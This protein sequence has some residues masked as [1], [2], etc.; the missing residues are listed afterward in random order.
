M[1]IVQFLI[2]LGLSINVSALIKVGFEFT[3]HG[4][5]LFNPTRTHM[6]VK[7]DKGIDTTDLH[8]HIVYPDSNG[9]FNIPT[10]FITANSTLKLT[11]ESLD[12]TFP[13]P[14]FKLS[15][16]SNNTYE[17]T[18]IQE[19][20]M[21]LTLSNPSTTNVTSP[22][23]YLILQ[24]SQY[25]F[26]P[27]RFIPADSLKPSPMQMMQSIPFLA[28][29]VSSKWTIGI[30]ILLVSLAAIP[31]VINFFDPGFA[32]RM[33][34]AQLEQQRAEQHNKEQQQKKDN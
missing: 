5:A 10:D 7:P 4:R 18:I 2:L 23:T 34:Q 16:P 3:N 26:Y 8:P 22:T 15:I 27:L 24:S 33:L 31:Y 13:S 25:G 30:F 28:P 21:H 32:E 11:I 6:F 1:R 9:D 19:D 29:I 20:P 14:H 12:Y 17:T